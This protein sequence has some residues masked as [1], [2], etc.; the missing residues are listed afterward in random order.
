M[1]SEVIESSISLYAFAKHF[2]AFFSKRCTT[3]TTTTT[4]TATLHC[5]LLCVDVCNIA[6]CVCVCLRMQ[7]CLCV[8]QIAYA[9]WH[10]RFCP[11]TMQLLI[12]I[13]H[14]LHGAREN[15]NTTKSTWNISNN[16]PLLMWKRFIPTWP[17]EFNE[18]TTTKQKRKEKN[19]IEEKGRLM[20]IDNK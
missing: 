16:N 4:T 7:R 15:E 5:T 17:N 13:S 9:H 11:Q 10:I 2:K 14:S 1:L 12:F 18:T 20:H 3:T 8:R 6:M 19:R